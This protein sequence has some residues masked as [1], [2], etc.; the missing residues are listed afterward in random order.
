MRAEAHLLFYYN[1]KNEENKFHS[2]TLTMNFVPN[3]KTAAEK[4]TA[5][6]K[7]G[8]CFIPLYYQY[9]E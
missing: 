6:S 8:I 3:N 9:F 7:T 4:S 5:V 2:F 1:K